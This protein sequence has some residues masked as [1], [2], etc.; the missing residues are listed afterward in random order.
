MSY[1]VKPS[2]L[3]SMALFIVLLAEEALKRA[4]SRGIVFLVLKN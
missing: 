3:N 2:S 1:W 4:S